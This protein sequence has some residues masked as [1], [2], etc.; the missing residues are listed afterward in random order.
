MKG[1]KKAEGEKYTKAYNKPIAARL[2]AGLVC[3]GKCKEASEE[4]ASVRS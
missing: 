1:I 3:G 4:T 2:R